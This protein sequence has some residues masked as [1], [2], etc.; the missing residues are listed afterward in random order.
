[1]PFSRAPHGGI[2][3]PSRNSGRA[4]AR[5]KASRRAGHWARERQ[6]E[7]GGGEVGEEKP[8]QGGVLPTS[9][10]PCKKRLLCPHV[11]TGSP[12][13]AAGAASASVRWLLDRAQAC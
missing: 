4:G 6:I 8:I 9:P 12:P 7:Q 1:M 10:P 5:L 3:R 2:S 11:A 13:G